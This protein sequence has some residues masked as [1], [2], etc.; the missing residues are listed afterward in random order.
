MKKI[1]KAGS[2]LNAKITGKVKHG[3]AALGDCIDRRFQS[4]K[5]ISAI[6]TWAEEHPRL[7]FKYAIGVFI[8]LF[9][10]G[11]YNLVYDNTTSTSENPHIKN[12]LSEIHATT[13]LI[14]RMNNMHARGAR[15]NRLSD[16]L[17]FDV[18]KIQHEIDSITKRKPL[19]HAD[20]VEVAWRLH[21]LEV[22]TNTLKS[23]E[24]D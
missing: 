24:K 14:T 10:A 5:K 9:I 16:E 19:S 23:D 21:K 3:L 8:L 6:N 22:I 15:I 20:T 13:D 2:R 7:F 1:K 4:R 11:I 17:R 12:T 18:A